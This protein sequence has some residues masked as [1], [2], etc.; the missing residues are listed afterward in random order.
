MTFSQFC[1]I[2]IHVLPVDLLAVCDEID[3][4]FGFYEKRNI[5]FKFINRLDTDENLCERKM[6]AFFIARNFGHALD[7]NH[8]R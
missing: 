3:L 2:T 4:G 1:L 8:M 5:S 6:K 7:H